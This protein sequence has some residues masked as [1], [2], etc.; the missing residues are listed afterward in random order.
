MKTAAM[1]LGIVGGCVAL[2]ISLFAILGGIM[3][4]EVITNIE[5]LQPNNNQLDIDEY[6]MEDS[7]KIGGKVFL[8]IG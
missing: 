1:V 5:D 2:I 3:F 8:G 6:D 7:M 4:L